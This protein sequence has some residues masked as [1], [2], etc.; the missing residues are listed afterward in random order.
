MV[1]QFSSQNSLIINKP[2]I[3]SQRTLPFYSDYR[4]E[5]KSRNNNLI[6]FKD[7]L[8][9][10][11]QY[12]SFKDLSRTGGFQSQIS[13]NNNNYLFMSNSFYNEKTKNK[14]I[15]KKIQKKVFKINLSSRN[16]SN[17]SKLKSASKITTGSSSKVS[18]KNN[19]NNPDYRSIRRLKSSN[20]NIT[21]QKINLTNKI[22]STN[23]DISRLIRP[24]NSSKMKS[25][26][27]F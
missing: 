12:N 25:K 4:I 19:I 13:T 10:F 14:Q 11:K 27:I 5:D 20:T 7:G 15:V 3:T 2:I 17:S 1:G 8:K 23:F 22:T 26:K 24:T 21:S 6:S 18:V 16:N 9:Q